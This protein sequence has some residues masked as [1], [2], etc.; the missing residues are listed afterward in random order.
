SIQTNTYIMTL[1]D[2]SKSSS[3]T[4]SIDVTKAREFLL[5]PSLSTLVEFVLTLL[6]IQQM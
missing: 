6:K 4:S 1:A 5:G 3:S 2:I